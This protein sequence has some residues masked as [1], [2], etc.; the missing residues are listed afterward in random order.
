MLSVS[1]LINHALAEN[2]DLAKI[3]PIIT[4]A[5]DNGTDK[6][7][8]FMLLYDKIHGNH[9]CSKYCVI[10]VE[11]M[12]H[13]KEKGKKWTLDQTDMIADKLNISFNDYSRYEFWCVVHLMYY[14]FNKL[15]NQVELSC[16]EIYGKLADKF[17]SNP[18]TQGK[19]VNYFFVNQ[20]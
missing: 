15:F 8:V 13:N 11:Q 5:I 3:I 1:E 17:L 10:L 4:T 20:K 16:P 14:K 12:Y 9:L 6:K 18:K 19:L 7:K 2:V